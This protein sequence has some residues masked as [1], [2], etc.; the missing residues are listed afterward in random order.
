MRTSVA[1]LS[2]VHGSNDVRIFHK[3]CKS[4]VGAGYETYF[5]VKAE[6][7]GVR[8]GVKIIALPKPRSRF[9]RFTRLIWLAYSRAL[10][11]GADLYHIHDPEL[12]P[13]GIVF[14]VRGK[15]VIWDAHEDVPKQILSKQWI[16]RPLRKPIALVVD[17]LERWSTKIFDGVIAATPSI[18]KRFPGRRTVVVQNFPKLDELVQECPSR[19]RERANRILYIGGI[20]KTRG[21]IELLDALVIVNEKIPAKLDLA[22][23]FSDEE[24]LKTAKLHPGWRF[25]NFHGWLSREEVLELLCKVKIGTVTLHATPNHIESYPTKMFEY[26]AAGLPVVASDFPLWRDILGREQRGVLVN[27]EDPNM[28]AQAFID[29]LEDPEKAE[30]MGLSGKKAIAD[31]YNWGVEEEKLLA[32]YEEVIAK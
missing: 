23:V 28:I 15:R 20:S 1:H 9:E 22:G 3:E 26:M 19:Y 2:T 27:P 11:T 14:K 6:S 17:L 31:H 5:V 13:L 24:L 8:E 30:K 21:L 4:L 7:S 16:P 32:L 12:I 10:A 25:V 18:A 29:I